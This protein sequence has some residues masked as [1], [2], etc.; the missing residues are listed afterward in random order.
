MDERTTLTDDEPD[1]RVLE[2]PHASLAD[3]RHGRLG[4]RRRDRRR[5]RRVGFRCRRGRHGRRRRRQRQLG[6]AAALARCLAPADARRVPARRSG[7]ARRC[8]CRATSR[9]GSPSCSR[10]ADAERLVTATGIRMPAFRL[11]KAGEQIGGYVRD[12]PWRPRPFTNAVDVRRVLAEFADGA[13]IVLQALHITPRAGRRLRARARARARAPGAGQRLLHAAR[14]PGAARAP[15]H[16]RRLRAPGR[17]ARSGGSSTSRCSSCRCGRSATRRR[18]VARAV[19]LDVTLRAGRHAL[20]PA[21][22]APR[23]GD[24]RARTPST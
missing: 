7:S 9:T 11:V 24:V 14:R 22:L 4:R 20:P 10:G 15:R 18:S 8:T 21:R 2:R 3:R 1:R 5:R 17:R 12:I 19:V 6:R 16:P 23:G 13:T